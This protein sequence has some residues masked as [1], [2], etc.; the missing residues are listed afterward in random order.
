MKFLLQ[1]MDGK[2]HV[3]M[4]PYVKPCCVFDLIGGASPSRSLP[5]RLYLNLFQNQKN[6]R[7]HALSDVVPPCYNS[8]EGGVY[9]RSQEQTTV[10][11]RS[12]AHLLFLEDNSTNNIHEK[13]ELEPFIFYVKCIPFSYSAV[14]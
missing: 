11:K 6:H 1:Q 12:R 3:E 10:F 13:Y 8:E 5:L 7:W 4:L 14:I 2:R 9:R